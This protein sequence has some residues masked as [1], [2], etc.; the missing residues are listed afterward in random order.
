M[1]DNG[2]VLGIRGRSKYSRHLLPSLFTPTPYLCSYLCYLSERNGRPQFAVVTNEPAHWPSGGCHNSTLFPSGSMTQANFPY[3]ES[4][5]LSSTLQPS[6]FKA[7]TN[8]WRS[9]T[10]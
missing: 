8:A 9:S 1:R 4:S 3:S 7:F 6:S 2:P 5:I 10:R